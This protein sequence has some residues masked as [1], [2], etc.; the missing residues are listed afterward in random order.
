MILQDSGS[1]GEPPG[2]VSSVAGTTLPPWK[3]SKSGPLSASA[4]PGDPLPLGDP[5]THPGGPGRRLVVTFARPVDLVGALTR[6][7]AAGAGEVPGG[8]PAAQRRR[9]GGADTSV[10]AYRLASGAGGW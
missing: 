3:S 1:L 8:A 9:G 10:G 2:R 4:A 5:R 7:L 6:P